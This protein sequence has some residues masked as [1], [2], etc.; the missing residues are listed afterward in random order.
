MAPGAHQKVG[1]GQEEFKRFEEELVG[2]H[3]EQ[4]L[5]EMKGKLQEMDGAAAEEL[6]QTG[7][8]IDKGYVRRR[9]QTS[10]G[11]VWVRI[12][13]LKRKGGS[14]SVYGLFAVCG[15]SRVSERAQEHCV[16]VAVGQSYETSRETLRQLSGMQMSRM[17]IWKVVQ[18]KGKGERERVEE[19]RQKVFELGEI[20]VSDKPPKKAVVVEIDGTMLASREVT[21]IEEVKGKRKMEVKLGVAFTGT[22]LV[23]K[24]RRRSVER[25]VYGEIARAEEFG[26]RWYGECLRH[27]I[28]PETR[29]HLIAD[30]AAWIRNLQRAIH[31]GSRY[32]LDAYHLQ[33]AAREVLTERQYQ[34][35]RSLVWSNHA[36][37]ALHYVERLQPSD[38][39]HREELENFSAYLERNLDGMRYDRPGP[40]GSGVVEKAA[41]VVVGRRMKRRGMSWSRQGANNLLALRVRSLNEAFDRRAR[42]P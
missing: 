11:A 8:Y 22:K 10:V 29:V 42:Q 14:G 15:V 33:K 39:E 26:E 17:G 19:Q 28:G 20:P 25:R 24:N 4:M 31:P 16:Q 37:A 23:S 27:G 35:F 9:V 21:D 5:Q 40:V 32:T 2:R 1:K 41:D 34:H 12:K 30:G 13:R 38:R 3:R 18:A 7:R 6:L 36:H